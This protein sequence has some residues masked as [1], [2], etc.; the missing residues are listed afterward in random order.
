MHSLIR[1]CVLAVVLLYARSLT[2][3]QTTTTQTAAKQ[4]PAFITLTSD[5]VTKA[6]TFTDAQFYSRSTSVIFEVNK[7]DIRRGDPFFQLYHDKI[8][9]LI[10]DSHLQLRKIYI[11]G[12]ASPE[13]PYDNNQRLG[14]GR[15]KALLQ[16]LQRGLK[17]QY[18]NIDT[19][20][21]SINEDYGYL[22]LLLREAHDPA[23]AAVQHIYDD[24]K[25]D[26][27]ACKKR[28]MATDNGKLWNR[29]V[30]TYFPQL[31]AARLMLWFSVPDS[32]HAPAPGPAVI[33]HRDTVY[34][35]DTLY[36]RRPVVVDDSVPPTGYGPMMPYV[37]HGKIHIGCIHDTELHPAPADTLQR[38]PLFALKTN[39]LFDVATFLNAEL[40][41]PLRR[42]G[43]LMAEVVWPW[44]LQRSHNRWCNEMGSVSLEGRWWFRP[45]QYHSTY[46]QWRDTRR[47]PLTHGFLG[48]YIGAGYYD[49]QSPKTHNY[50]EGISQYEYYRKGRQGEFVSAGLTLGVSRYIGRR[51]RFEASIGL[52]AAYTEYRSY[53]VDSNSETAPD[54]DQHLWRDEH[55]GHYNNIGWLNLRHNQPVSDGRYLWLGPTKAKLS[56]V[57][58]LTKPCRKSKQQKG[59]A[60]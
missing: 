43:S 17:H 26:E 42:Q 46:R 40:E 47:A 4:L 54:R 29:L 22:C 25:G 55:T 44:W 49:F 18:L 6:P 53:H 8:L 56:I 37:C 16:E 59:G 31:R 13:G 19:E 60:R 15:S 33:T 21:S 28:L 5:T 7:T 23:Y 48:A 9:P 1:I 45:W 32:A 27:V 50:P 58:L 41:V 30:K 24:S 38:H 52:G 3:A 14:R 39:L 51:A 2:L 20:I 35:N 57:W 36:V 12:A 34:I 11:R 10:N